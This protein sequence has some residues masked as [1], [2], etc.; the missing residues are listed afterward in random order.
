[1]PDTY[2][3]AGSDSPAAA[4]RAASGAR[5][6]PAGTDGQEPR[7]AGRS[8][9]RGPGGGR[10]RPGACRGEAPSGPGSWWGDRAGD[11]AGRERAVAKRHRARAPGGGLLPDH[12]SSSSPRT[13]RGRGAPRGPGNGR[14]PCAGARG[15]V[16][17]RA[18]AW[19]RGARASVH[20]RTVLPCR[21]ARRSRACLHQLPC[22]GAHARVR[23]W[24]GKRA[25]RDGATCAGGRDR[26]RGVPAPG[27]MAAYRLRERVEGSA[28]ER[29]SRGGRHDRTRC[30]L[31]QHDREP[32]RHV[33]G[34]GAVPA[35][36]EPDD[37]ART[38]P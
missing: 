17:R 24:A 2:R 18:P 30:R 13:L 14:I 19:A 31:R 3:A 32:A 35:D 20:S 8:G 34:A 15:P 9:S 21:S 12:G 1:M 25:G 38:P 36:P 23:R 7:R 6:R 22:S 27:R 37:P 16:R 10:R 28:S 26:S 29:R 11:A 33:P 4:G 5:R